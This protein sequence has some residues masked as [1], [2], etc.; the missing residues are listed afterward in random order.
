MLVSKSEL[1]NIFGVTTVTIDDWLRID[2][3]YVKQGGKGKAW[4]FDTRDVFAWRLA[5]AEKSKKTEDMTYNDLVNK[6]LACEIEKLQ[7]QN[8]KLKNN[9]LD[10]DIA[11]DNFIKV[12]LGIKKNMMSLPARSALRLEG[13]TTRTEIKFALE[14][15]LNLLLNNIADDLNLFEVKE[16]KE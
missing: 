6:K 3:P 2:C 8:S 15:E 5:H 16:D 1:A 9:L 13:C 12:I 4:Q 10:A 14:D 11:T 7:I